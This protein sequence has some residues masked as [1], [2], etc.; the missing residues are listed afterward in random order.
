MIQHNTFDLVISKM[1]TDGTLPKKRLKLLNQWM[2]ALITGDRETYLEIQSKILSIAKQLHYAM[3]HKQEIKT[4]FLE[5]LQNHKHPTITKQEFCDLTYNSVL[6]Q[7]YPYLTQEKA[8][9]KIA[10]RFREYI[11]NYYFGNHNE[12]S[13]SDL[14]DKIHNYKIIS[15]T[16]RTPQTQVY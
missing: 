11:T 5:I 16:A 7:S 4:L 10:R 15:M 3:S 9:R 1:I 6:L 8:K 14:L 2:H 13:T 12:L